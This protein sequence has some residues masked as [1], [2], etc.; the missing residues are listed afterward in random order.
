[1]TYLL[2]NAYL[3]EMCTDA[4]RQA[5]DLVQAFIGAPILLDAAQLGAAAHCVRLFWTNML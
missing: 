5:G 1:M 3:G 4:V 2:E